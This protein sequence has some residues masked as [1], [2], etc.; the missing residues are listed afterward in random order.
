MFLFKKK[1]LTEDAQ[2]VKDII[3]LYSEKESIKKLISPISN[4][5]FIIDENNQI[6]ICISDG[7]VTI[8]NHIFLY[9]KLFNF[10]FTEELK[11]IVRKSME[12]EMQSLKKS[13]FK[14]ETQLLSKVFEVASD[15]KASSIIKPDFSSEKSEKTVNQKF[16]K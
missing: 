12:Q 16:I 3:V 8:S 13:L 14:N 1:E 6:Y 15:V 4:E 7:K 5:F 9:K 11:K 10:S 2:Y